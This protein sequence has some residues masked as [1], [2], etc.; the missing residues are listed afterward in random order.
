MNEVVHVAFK[1][2]FHVYSGNPIEKQHDKNIFYF[3]RF[4]N[5]GP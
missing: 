4:F 1:S 2:F 5:Y 3:F